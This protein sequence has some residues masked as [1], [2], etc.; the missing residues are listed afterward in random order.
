[1]TTWDKIK[2][3]LRHLKHRGK[4]GSGDKY[5]CLSPLREEKQPSFSLLVEADGEHGA[6]YD[7]G[8][9]ESGSLYQLAGQM[10]IEI[11]YDSVP[12]R[13]RS[14]PT[15]RSYTG[16]ADYAQAHGVSEAVFIAAGW[17][18]GEHH[19]R[20]ALLYPVETGT[21]LR[22]L[23]DK[24]AKYGWVEAGKANCW[25]GLTRALAI[26]NGWH[27]LDPILCNG[28]ASTVVAQHFGL[29]AFSAVGGESSTSNPAMVTTLVA[30]LEEAGID[31]LIIALDCDTAGVNAANAAALALKG[32]LRRVIVLDLGLT[33]K[34]D[35]SDFC[36][37]YQA[38]SMAEIEKRVNLHLRRRDEAERIAEDARRETVATLADGADNV[39]TLLDRVVTQPIINPFSTLHPFGGYAHIFRPGLLY[40]AVGASGGMKTSFLEVIAD[41]LMHNNHSVVWWGSEWDEEGMALRALTRATGIPANDLHLHQLALLGRPDGKRIDGEKETMIRKAMNAIKERQQRM[42]IIKP[43]AGDIDS[44]LTLM[45]TVIDDMRRDGLQARVVMLDYLQLLSRSGRDSAI[46]GMD[47][48][49]SEYKRFAMQYRVV[50]WATSQTPKAQQRAVRDNS[51][52]FDGESMQYARADKFN[53]LLGLNIPRNPANPNEAPTAG[54]ITVI[55]NSDGR[56]GHLWVKLLIARRLWMDERAERP[57]WAR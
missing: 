10:G 54:K 11:D 31:G 45:G 44:V 27:G 57:S 15:A 20:P 50:A 29:P 36:R 1:M 51:A 6:F 14:E 30:R 41:K 38:G 48:A 16:L 17:R 4:K 19:N 35:L 37:L 13:N 21:R 22:F 33:N 3:R 5:T 18:E 39:L 55:K 40:G 56:P 42:T 12:T 9:G 43:E 28:E 47:H 7:F 23:D 34:G 49:L 52:D 46:E 32:K 26:T 24:G 8:A 25:Y 2:P 53:L